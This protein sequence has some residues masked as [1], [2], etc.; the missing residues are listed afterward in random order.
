[1][2]D[3][4]VAI[5]PDPPRTGRLAAIAWMAALAVVAGCA[6]AGTRPAPP[7]GAAP[8]ETVR[9]SLP[10]G[11][12]GVDLYRPGAAL[13][14]P[15]VIVA[16]GFSRSRR[17]MSGWGQRLAREGYVAAVPDL[18]AWSDPSRNGR[19]V[20]EL[21]AYLTTVEPFRGEV[22]G[23]RVGLVG[24]SAGGLATLLSAAGDPAPAIWVGLDPVDRDGLGTRAA[25]RLRCRA[26]VL[27]AEPSACNAHGNLRGI[28]A[29]L[30]A[31]ELFPVPGAVHVDAE[32]PTSWLAEA[33]C[34]RSTQAR[35]EEFFERA[36]R[37]LRATLSA[38]PAPDGAGE[39]EVAWR[40]RA[41]SW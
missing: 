4:G 16:H 5:V 22:D 15:L 32:A 40:R 31:Y 3:G 25:A 34:G 9:V 17:N 14:A 35:R 23:S 8:V 7:T 13:P 19:F 27:T 6:A 2:P 39:E 24:F 33:V 21:R 20:S 38:Q 18:P 10:A 30:R 41:R 12:A 1:M 37:A 11:A 36:T 26:V 28:L 29:A